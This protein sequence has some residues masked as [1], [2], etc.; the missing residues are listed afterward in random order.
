MRT[1][2][3]PPV[4]RT[5]TRS[6]RCN[7][8]LC[9][10]LEGRR[11]L[12]G[13]GT[14]D[15][16]FNG[17]GL[18][19]AT[20]AGGFSD[21]GRAVAVGSNGKTV[22][23]GD[24]GMLRVNVNG[25]P[26]TTFGSTGDGRVR[27]LAVPHPASVA[28]QADQKILVFGWYGESYDPS[29]RVARYLV[30]GQLD[31]SFNFDGVFD[32]SEIATPGEMLVQ[33]DGK[34]VVTGTNKFLVGNHDFVIMRL[35]SSGLLDSTFG[36][37][38]FPTGHTGLVKAGFGD[39]DFAQAVAIDE[40]GSLSTNPLYGSI[41]VAGVTYADVGAEIAP[42][43]AVAR[44]TRNGVA[45]GA[46][47][48]DGKAVVVFPGA[49]S[50]ATAVVLQPGGKIVVGGQSNSLFALARLNSNGTLDTTFGA[51]GT[52]RVFTKFSGNDQLRDLLVSNAGRLIA[53]GSAFGNFA[54]AA[55]T[56]NGILDPGFSGDGKLTTEFGATE[57]VAGLARGPGNTFVA[58]G[59][60]KSSNQSNYAIARYNDFG[61]DVLVYSGDPN[62]AEAGPNTASV[63]F[64]RLQILPYS[65]RVYYTVGGTASAPGTVASLL[66]DYTGVPST[67]SL[68]Y[69]DIP[70]NQSAVTLTITPKDDNRIESTETVIVTI[71]NRPGYTPTTPSVATLKIVDNDAATTVTFAP[72]A[73]AYVRDGGTASTNFG[74]ATELQVKT[75]GAPNSGLNR[76]IYLKFDL[77]SATITSAKLRLFGAFNDVGTNS[78]LVNVNGADDVT[79][80]EN[81][82]NWNNKPPVTTNGPITGTTITGTTPAW[83]EWDVTAYLKAQQAL[84]RTS[85][86]LVLRSPAV[87][88]PYVKF[89]SREA[90]SNGPQLVVRVNG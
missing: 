9:E 79:W 13:A 27:S 77:T 2:H 89:N 52:G 55:Y 63:T 1:S 72:T 31:K 12:S 90:A 57:S 6:I 47:S 3:R 51:S 29:M 87:T 5:V 62:A 68:Q 17:S 84:G 53:G 54:I 74:G 10:V 23:V 7:A 41:V 61:P 66:T 70:A 21:A 85:V 58:G 43:M 48:G 50:S 65:T 11:L 46:F 30:N 8:H 80:S 56:A 28:I 35:T 71:S 86:T 15:T 14:L 40:S 83:Y 16:S 78:G 59:T 69:V 37:I 32:S 4:R 64:S 24:T 25:T 44:I 36:N 26:D 82:I 67:A 33:R 19:N 39:E 60:Y 20:I 75:N 18:L 22:I 34:I 88:D 73:D 45:D 38:A 42:Q 76:N 81:T 49:S